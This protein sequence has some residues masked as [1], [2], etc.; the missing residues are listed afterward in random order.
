MFF[1]RV[2]TR[3]HNSRATLPSLVVLLTVA[4]TWLWA[5]EGHAPLPTR[6]AQVD[7]AKGIVTLSREARDVLDVKT[8]EVAPRVVDEKV[9]AYAT[10]VAPWQQHAYATTSIPGR[11]AKV[12]VKPG[13]PVSA[14]QPLAEV[15]S[16]ELENLQ[17]EILNSQNDIQLSARNV[18]QLEPLAK[19]EAIPDREVR[20]AQAKHQQN[21]NT[22]DITRAKWL[23]LGLSQ[24]NFDKLL[25]ERNPQLIR[26]LPISSPIGGTLIHVDAAV[27]RVIEPSEHLFEIV[28]LSRVWVQIG[29]LE[30]DLYKIQVGQPVEVKLT[31]YAQEVFRTAVQ[32]KGVYLDPQSHLG[33]VW[34]ELANPPGQEPRFLPGMYGQAKIVL[35]A[36]KKLLTVPPDALIADG[37]ERYVLVENSATA[38]ASEYQKRNIVTGQQ[39]RDLVQVS[40]GDVFAGDRVVTAGSHELSSFF[41]Q[42]VLRLSPEAKKNIRLRIE[43][44]EPQVVE[45]VVEVDGVVDV[46]PD[47]RAFASSQLTGN[48]RKINVERG[49]AV[50]AG[51]ILGEIASLELQ[52]IQLEL[53]RAHL[54]MGLLEG[55]LQ[56]LRRADSALSQKQLW[57]TE[58]LYNE[59]RNRRDSGQR[60]LEAVGLTA[61]QVKAILAEKKLV[62]TVPL[63]SPIDGNVVHFDRVLGQIVKAD[64]PLFEVHDLSQSWIQ[65]FVSERELSSV[66]LGQASRVRLV[67]DPTFHAEATVVRSGRVFGSDSR[68]LSVW[69]E[70]KRVPNTILQHNM[71]ARL[72]LTLERP[73][74]HLALPLAAV[75][76][77]GTRAYAFVQRP[78][79]ILERRTVETGR[80]DDRFV[81]IISGL[82]RGELVAVQGAADLQTAYA[83]VR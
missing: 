34:S 40:E 68:T 71:L 12:Y 63:R 38:K 42:G 23:S 37:S 67:S 7:L 58:S 74:P 28:D 41:I 77:E 80:A 78:D 11:I 65:A 44:V 21:L 3:F 48:L 36:P 27:G 50:R 18:E 5:H 14:G 17:L 30:Q 52:N 69:V 62:K 72:S 75:V 13:Q 25:S 4:V 35:P 46:P 51:D 9:L 6:G 1:L 19:Q 32:V 79:G 60:K 64:E 24:D 66:R 20:E 81:E 83:S 31:A 61:E 54:Q 39:T 55:T 8:A 29:V 26:S 16:L 70:L 22:L 49:Q 59:T 33:T 2:A 53:L 43:P 73:A 15:Q 47:R 76:R 56:R 10:L 45:D 82:Q 57:E